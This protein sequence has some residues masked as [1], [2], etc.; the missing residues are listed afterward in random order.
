[1]YPAGK[2]GDRL[3][4]GGQRGYIEI[5]NYI[6]LHW[7]CHL[8]MKKKVLEIMGRQETYIVVNKSTLWVA[9][10]WC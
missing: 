8:E 3:E 4:E 7:R 10:K 5:L 6:K 1:M 2:Q 9:I